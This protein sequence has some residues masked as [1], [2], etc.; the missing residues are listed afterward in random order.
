MRT[1]TAPTPAV[2][3]V[4]QAVPEA[5]I[6]PSPTLA[7]TVTGG[8]L[9]STVRAVPCSSPWATTLAL[10]SGMWAVSRMGSLSVA[11]GIRI[12]LVN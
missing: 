12:Y 1:A 6:E 11:S 5:S 2:F 7:T 4:F 8:V 3:Q 10:F 9:M